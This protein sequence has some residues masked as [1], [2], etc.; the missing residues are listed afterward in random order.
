MKDIENRDD[1]F[2]LVS[3]FYSEI[4]KDDILAPIFNSHIENDKWPEHLNKLTDFWMTG[5]FGVICFK[6]NPTEAHRN[7]DK[8][9]NHII[10]ETHFDTWLTLWFSTIDSLYVGPLAS[11]A[12]NAAVKMAKGQ[13]MAIGKARPQ[14]LSNQ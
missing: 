10:D 1:L 6:G 13:H 5:L 9:L 8:N 3:T 2:L 4:R 12:K 11:R 7:V 14:A